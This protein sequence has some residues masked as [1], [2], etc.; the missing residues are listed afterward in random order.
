MD[1]QAQ[2]GREEL[3]HQGV[4]WLFV[5]LVLATTFAL[6]STSLYFEFVWDDNA[7]IQENFRIQALD[8]IHIK[9][10][11]TKTYLGHFAPLHHQLLAIIYH[12]AEYTPF[13][14][15]LVNVLLHMACIGMAFAVVKKLESGICA[16]LACI[17]YA[18]HP[19]N[20]ETV[21]WVSE[22]KSIL[23]FLFFL[24][25]FWFYMRFRDSGQNI[26]L[27]FSLL[28][29]VCSGLTK[30]NTVVAPAVFVFYEYRSAASI[31]KYP[32]RTVSLFFLTSLALTAAHLQAFGENVEMLDG[33]PYHS[34][35]VRLM[36]FPLLLSFYLD[37]MIAPYNL[38]AWELF[39]VQESF[40]WI[41]ALGWAGLVL[42]FVLLSRAHRRTQFWSLW[43]LVFLLPVLQIVPFPV[44]VADRYLYIPLLGGCALMAMAVCNVWQS[45]AR[46]S[47]R[48]A[49]GSTTACIV[50]LLAWKTH[51]QLPV[52]RDDLSLWSATTP[53]CRT[54][55]YCRSS[56]GLAL[57][58]RGYLQEGG[59]ELVAATQIQPSPMFLIFLGDA[60]TI[61]ARNYPEAIR[62]Y[63]LALK[64]A[65]PPGSDTYGPR[66]ASVYAKLARAQYRTGDLKSMQESIRK[67]VSYEIRTP[68]LVIADIF[69]Q[70]KMR[71]LEAARGSLDAL[72]L[73]TGESRRKAALIDRFWNDPAETKR[74]LGDISHQALNAS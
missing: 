10:F 66:H 56:L 53:K 36:N 68:P 7:Y 20:V 37:T 11:W 29:Y 49:I 6:Y 64:D 21:A 54:S 34:F 24:L 38:S 62:I 18:V 65:G 48:W 58:S 67:G 47:M 71:N 40:N 63:R 69:L 3:Q 27:A 72:V 52:W 31:K 42:I 22:S 25:S 74:V 45:S 59:N 30:I 32:W 1:V 51:A 5:E 9:S 35:A 26:F 70:Y 15:H 43:I 23:A 73:M 60:L 17:L 55:G 13:L 12:F 8:W 28:L 4:I 33:V 14:Y 50:I 44:W 2:V 61:S 39:P 16:F 41:V 46:P 19:T 57:M